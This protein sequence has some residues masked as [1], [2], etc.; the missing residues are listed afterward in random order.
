MSSVQDAL[1]DIITKESGIDRSKI[2]LD[3]GSVKGLVEVIEKLTPAQPA[4]QP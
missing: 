1:F 3:T 2:T 4:V